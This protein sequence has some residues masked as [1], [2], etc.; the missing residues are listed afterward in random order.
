MKLGGATL[1]EAVR[2][3]MERVIEDDFIQQYSW[4]GQKQKKVFGALKTAQGM[5]GNAI[6]SFY[7]LN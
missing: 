7:H 2:R 6:F 4:L 3:T 5:K 1:A